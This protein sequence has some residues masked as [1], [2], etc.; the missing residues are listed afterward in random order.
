MNL[1]IAEANELNGQLVE[2]AL[3][4]RRNHLN[5]VGRA[6]GV[7]QAIALLKQTQPDIALVSAELQEGPFEGFHLLREIRSLRLRTRGIM[8]LGSHEPSLVVDAFRFGARGVIFRDEPLETLSKCIHVVHEGQIWASSELLG[9]VMEA[10]GRALPSG[11][12][13][14]EAMHL[15]SKRETDVVRLV[16]QG[17]T[18]KEVSSELG[19]SEHTIRNYLFR[20][21]DKLGVS[22]RV[23]LVLYCLQVKAP[24]SSRA[25]G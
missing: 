20:I 22:T 15:L 1:L 10:L 23:E 11:L 14:S 17:M 25:A 6:I 13:E 24:E 9:L 2:T 8:L 19:L 3:R 5:I 7:I 21:F 16:S 18:N 4:S 12:R